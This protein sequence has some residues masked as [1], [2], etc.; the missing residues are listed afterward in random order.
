M[1]LLGKQSISMESKVLSKIYRGKR[2]TS[3]HIVREKK[4]T[5]FC[6]IDEYDPKLL[7]FNKKIIHTTIEK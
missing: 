1:S 7:T 6:D 5:H 4:K 2:E 3:K